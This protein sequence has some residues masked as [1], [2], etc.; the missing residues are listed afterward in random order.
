MTNLMDK[1]FISMG[2]DG[3]EIKDTQI[4]GVLYIGMIYMTGLTSAFLIMA[5]FH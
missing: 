5:L 1:V 4:R 3:K 2:M